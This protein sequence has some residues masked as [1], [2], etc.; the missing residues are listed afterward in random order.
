[1]RLWGRYPYRGYVQIKDGS[2]W[3]YLINQNWDKNKQKKLCQHLGFKSTKADIF[4]GAAQRELKL[5]EGS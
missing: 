2:V 4:L 5:Q 3:R 1:M